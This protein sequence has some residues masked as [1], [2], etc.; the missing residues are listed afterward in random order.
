MKKVLLMVLVLSVLF[1]PFAHAGASKPIEM[2]LGHFAADAHEG[3]LASK[4]FAEAVE[5]RTNGAIK[6]TIYP[7]NALGAPPAEPTPPVAAAAARLAFFFAFF[8]WL[9]DSATAAPLP[10]TS[11]A[12]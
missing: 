12:A 6:V 9:L 2:K 11:L 5:K 7:N 10:A 3:N 8:F 1:I 4:M